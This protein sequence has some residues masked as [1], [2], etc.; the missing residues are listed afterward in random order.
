MIIANPT[1]GLR[2]L[3][4]NGAGLGVNG[5]AVLGSAAA[6]LKLSRLVKGVSKVERG[7]PAKMGAK[8]QPP[9]P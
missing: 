2:E 3:V 8:G 9:D 7:L 5:G 1:A 4:E 6:S